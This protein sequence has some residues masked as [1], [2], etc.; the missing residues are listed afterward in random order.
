VKD[1]TYKQILALKPGRHWVSESLYVHVAPNEQTRRF[2][3]RFT[4][5]QTKR[6][7]EKG[8]GR[9]DKDITLTEAKDNRDG[10]RRLVRQ[11]GDPVDAKRGPAT[12]VTFASV[13]SDYIEVQ[14]RRFR[15]PNS[16]KNVRVLLLRRASDLADKPI[17]NIGTTH[18]DA[19]LRPLW[20]TS[21]D[22]ARRA[23]A[24]V[25]RVLKYAKAKGLSTASASEMRDDMSHLLPRVNG[26]KRHF[27]ALDYKDIPAFVR[28]LRAAQTQGDALSPAVIEFILLTACRENEVCGMQWSEIDWQERVW[29]LPLARDKT[30]DKR[31]EPRRIPLCDRLLVLLSRQRGPGL[32]REPPDPQ[33][34]VWPGRSGDAP[35]T[36]KSV[37]KYL[38]ETM[39]VKAT[40][41]G[42][43]SSFRDWAGDMTHYARNDIEECLGHAVGD[44]TER[45]YR[46]KDGLDKR[47]VI[48]EAWANHC[49]GAG[50]LDHKP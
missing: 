12:V 15:N 3:F 33:G 25:L 20:L 17:A 11:G 26:T 19:A 29:A 10:Y 43:R 7:S 5:P 27:T 31:T 16:V 44:S 42:F 49:A 48:M 6:V 38:V 14:A 46:R 32:M 8:L 37:Y 9:L 30:G 40:I 47:R 24:A 35:V 23:V 36:G 2:M 4:K 50:P 28:E 41:H 34:Y 22:Q 45:A 18:I 13:A 1:L 21:P 39:G